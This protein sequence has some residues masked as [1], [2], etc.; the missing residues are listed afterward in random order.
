MT[1][2]DLVLGVDGGG[3]HT[4]VWLARR[5]LPTEEGVLGR[6]SAEASNPRT[7]PW[8]EAVGNIQS[9][10]EAAFL[11][12]GIRRQPVAAA[13]IGLAGADRE[14][15]RKPCRQWASEFRLADRVEVTNDAMPILY[16]ND[17]S[18]IGVALIAGTGSVAWGRREDGRTSRCGG[19]GP[20]MG[21]EGSGYAI[22]CAGLRSA[23]RAADRR[24]EATEILDALLTHFRVQSASELIPK[25][26]RSD[27]GR[28]EIAGLSSLVFEAAN[29]G[30]PV[31]RRIVDEAA[32]ELVQCALT[33][34]RD[35]KLPAGDWL[36]AFTG[37]VL[38]HH[39]ELQNRIAGH[40]AAAESPPRAW[41]QVA[42]PVA[43]A[44]RLAA[45]RANQT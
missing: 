36:L 34:V 10:V 35:L 29:R 31:A 18:G 3:S 43:G 9:A 7:R 8:Q 24:G 15:E 14:D 25:I 44:V 5:D 12:A 30:D 21:D 11:D 26:Y 37:G 32:G 6:G 19:W 4:R 22:A 33:V 28:P 41:V 20:L 13:C 45:M 42:R 16:A 17:E 2:N 23:A 38:L 27:F 39:P 40:L 1:T